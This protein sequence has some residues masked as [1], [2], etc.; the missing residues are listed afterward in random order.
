M[1]EHNL[2]SCCY[3]LIVWFEPLAVSAPGSVKHRQNSALATHSKPSNCFINITLL[4]KSSYLGHVSLLI[5]L[6]HKRTIP[7]VFKD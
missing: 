2:L 3:H 1:V 5:P 7:N 4:Y 6:F